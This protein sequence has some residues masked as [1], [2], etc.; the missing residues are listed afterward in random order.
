MAIRTS[1][2]MASAALIAASS[3]PICFAAHA[4]GSRIISFDVPGADLTPGDDNGTYV[5]SI[6]DWGVITGY[7]EDVNFVVHGFL[8]SSEGKYA[9][10]DAPGA[11]TAANSGAGTFPNSINRGRSGHHL[12]I[13]VA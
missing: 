13:C 5:Q 4:P 1:T 8:R 6:N 3:I 12:P 2:I 10:F 9:S 11:D 7:Y